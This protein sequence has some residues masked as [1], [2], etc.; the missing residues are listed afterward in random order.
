MVK[1]EVSQSVKETKAAALLA[2]TTAAVQAGEKS[3]ESMRHGEES[4]GMLLALLNSPLETMIN[5]NQARVV[6]SAL[7]IRK[8]GTTVPTTIIYFYNTEPTGNGTLKHAER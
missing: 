4:A 2:G 1:S 6:G 3:S 5:N 8:D 7:V